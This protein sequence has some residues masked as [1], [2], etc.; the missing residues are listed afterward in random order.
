MA[1]ID[2]ENRMIGDWSSFFRQNSTIALLRLMSLKTKELKLRFLTNHN[3]TSRKNNTVV[4]DHVINEQLVQDFLYLFLALEECITGLKEYPE[5]QKE[6]QSIVTSNL[7][8]SLYVGVEHIRRNNPKD[9]VDYLIQFGS[10]WLQPENDLVELPNS[11]TA[12]QQNIIIALNSVD[13]IK[14]SAV[15][16]YENVVLKSKS[17]EPN[18]ALLLT[19]HKLY[20]YASEKMN[21]ITSRQ[22]DAYFKDMLKFTINNSIPNEIF[23]DVSVKDGVGNCEIQKESKLLAGVNGDGEN[24]IY[25]VTEGVVANES[26]IDKIIGFEMDDRTDSSKMLTSSEVVPEVYLFS[27][28]EDLDVLKN[29]LGFGF[30]APYLNLEEGHRKLSFTVVFANNTMIAL[31]NQLEEISQV[32]SDSLSI[33][34][35]QIKSLFVVRY[36]GDEDWVDVNREDVETSFRLEENGSLA[37]EITITVF[38]NEIAPSIGVFDTPVE[39]DSVDVFPEFEFYINP[40]FKHFIFPFG[41]T[42]IIKIIVDIELLNIQN[43]LISNDFGEMDAEAPFQPFGSAPILGSTFY[44]GHRYL[45][46]YPLLDIKL[47]IEWFGLP[48]IDGGFGEHYELYEEIGGN[49]SFKVKISALNDK[50]WFPYENKQVVDLFQTVPNDDDRDTVSLFRRMNEF[51]VNDLMLTGNKMRKESNENYS[52][53]SMNGFIKLELCYPFNAFGH[54]DYPNLIRDYSIKNIK[55]KQKLYP[56]EP[57]TPTIKEI[58]C[59]LTSRMEFNST[60]E[61]DYRLKHI[62]PFGS[63]QV[64]CNYSLL[65]SMKKGSTLII[66]LANL[67][68]SS[69]ISFFFKFNESIVDDALKVSISGYDGKEWKVLE[70]DN[71]I[72]DSTEMF[73]RDGVI[74]I[75][76]VDYI[77]QM[78][79]IFSNE[80]TWFKFETNG[81]SFLDVLEDIRPHAFKARCL[82]QDLLENENIEPHTIT[83]FEI[84]QDGIDQLNQK[85]PSFGGIKKESPESFNIRAS[86]RLKHKGRAV[87]VEDVER[88]ILNKFPEVYRCVCFPYRDRFES[89]SPGEILVILVPAL[90]RIKNN[91]ANALFSSTELNNVRAFLNIRCPLNTKLNI[92][93]P[94]YER[95]RVK[96]NIRFKQGYDSK[97][98]IKKLDKDIK[99]FISPFLYTNESNLDMSESIQ[100]TRILNFIENLNY[101]EH[102]LNFSLFHIV[103]DKII[104]QNTAKLNSTEISPSKLT[105]ILI[106]DDHHDI[107]IYDDNDVTDKSG[108]NEMMIG[109]DYI[110]EDADSQIS[111]GLN[112]LEIEKN[113]HVFEDSFDDVKE[114]TKFTMFLNVT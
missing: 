33:I 88:L 92:K 81:F 66:A 51:E 105:S 31:R 11:T 44:I 102:I 87:N 74:K 65:P 52:S 110:V 69:S 2:S 48:L 107:T 57:Y 28:K 35:D 4:N 106:S 21:K 78:D 73:H 34:N 18:V 6:V 38:I 20:G 56:N 12:F 39:E 19:F 93:N 30:S 49:D 98:Y 95:V 83:A 67:K 71:I 96:M 85:F 109:T 70:N 9:K 113:Y 101:I 1:F 84:E 47:N 27:D 90:N 59:E 82:S 89:I 41:E 42:K 8:K 100:S 104:N 114:K 10:Y 53:S 26:F 68:D 25:E 24:I 29:G 50:E 76:K 61:S 16:Y 64:S 58:S 13:F 36:T 63:E 111:D 86:E 45:F 77:H 97:F 5:F 75:N 108:I 55:S 54:D 22:L 43:L 62:Y 60:N 14:N 79:S 80:Y 37:E 103:N 23:L 46:N 99:S 15:K 40:A 94:S 3:S 17:I 32:D 72:K 7:S 91:T 112:H